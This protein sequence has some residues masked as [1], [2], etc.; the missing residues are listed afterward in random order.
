MDASQQCVVWVCVLE[1]GTFVHASTE[2]NTGCPPPLLLLGSHF[3]LDQLACKPPESSHSLPKA[4][5]LCTSLVTAGSHVGARDPNSGSIRK[6]LALYP[7]LATHLQ[8]IDYGIRTPTSSATAENGSATK[9][10]M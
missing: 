7:L 8:E 9:H 3:S 4:L 1:R 6:R 5:G 2:V 10:E